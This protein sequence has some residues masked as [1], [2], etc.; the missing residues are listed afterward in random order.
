MFLVRMTTPPFDALYALPPA[1]PSSPSM[2][3][4]VTTEPRW[5]SARAGCRSIWAMTCFAVRNV[6]VR[7]TAIT[8]CPLADGQQ[9]HRAAAGHAGR[10]DQAV[11]RARRS[12]TAARDER[13][14]RR[15]VGHV[16]A[17]EV[18]PAALGTGPPATSPV[19]RRRR[20]P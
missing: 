18:P 1:V 12:A 11:D 6:P 13:L 14:D 9:V 7:L 3:A 2:L 16:D 15:L 8:R 4:M 5:P 10:V 17:G 20:P 19:A